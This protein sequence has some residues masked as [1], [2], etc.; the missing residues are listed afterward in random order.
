MNELKDEYNNNTKGL[1][2]D[3]LPLGLR[4]AMTSTWFNF[5]KAKVKNYTIWD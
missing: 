5:G 2:W 1:K 4:T 3:E